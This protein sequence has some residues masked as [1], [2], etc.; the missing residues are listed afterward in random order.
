MTESFN[1]L[2]FDEQVSSILWSQ[3]YHGI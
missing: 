3:S 2:Q 1:V